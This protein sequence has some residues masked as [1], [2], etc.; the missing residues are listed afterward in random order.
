[1]V[2]EFNWALKG[3]AEWSPVGCPYVSPTERD[4][5]QGFS[6][7]D[8]AAFTLRYLLIG[9]CSGMADQMVFWSLAA[10]GFGLVD[11]GTRS[12]GGSGG[13]GGGNSGDSGGGSGGGAGTPDAQWRPRPAFHALAAFFSLLRRAHYIRALAAGEKGVW[14]L[15]FSAESGKQIIAAWNSS[16]KKMKFKNA[17]E[18]KFTPSR[19]ADFCGADAPEPAE[20]DGCPVYIIQ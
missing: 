2:S 10:H 5:P 15:L 8:A 17:F 6:E 11:C 16:G 3:T 4:N 20:L 14:A 18:I 13:S 19:Y 12:G 1:V 9:I 7:A